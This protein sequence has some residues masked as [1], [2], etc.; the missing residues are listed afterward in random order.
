MPPQRSVDID[1]ADDFA[2]A[3]WHYARQNSGT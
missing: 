2:L 1:T 3:E